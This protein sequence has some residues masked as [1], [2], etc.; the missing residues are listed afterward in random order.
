MK[1][2]DHHVHLNSDP[3]IGFCLDWRTVSHRLD[4]YELDGAIIFST[5]NVSYSNKNPYLGVNRMILQASKDD[6]RLIPFSFIHPFYDETANF[7]KEHEQ[8][9]GFKLHQRARHLEYSYGQLHKSKVAE[10][11]IST[12]K[13]V[14]FHTGYR[15]GAR[16]KDLSYVAENRKSHLVFS[17]SGDLIDSDLRL[18]KK[19]ENVYIDV[20]PLVTMIERNFFVE[21]PRRSTELRILNISNILNYLAKLFGKKR[22]IWGSDSPWC[23]NL[24][25]EGYRKEVDVGKYMLEEGFC[26]NIFNE[27]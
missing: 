26:T 12:N 9:K 2:I 21:L 24:I 19:Y 20:S 11:I 17:H 18:V 6:K 14:F 3:K 4:H 25:E 13:P 8:F 27:L 22:I 10:F 15:E 7:E 23:D 16:I 1:I 5:P